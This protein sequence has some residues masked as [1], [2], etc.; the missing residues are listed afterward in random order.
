MN[1]HTLTAERFS[2]TT[3]VPYPHYLRE[4]GRWRKT[5]NPKETGRKE[6]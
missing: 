2:A 3:G 4:H 5:A 1:T 6:M